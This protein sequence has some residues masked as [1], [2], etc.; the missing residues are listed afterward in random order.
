MYMCRA[1]VNEY[2]DR[3]NVYNLDEFGAHLD[4]THRF[5]KNVL[6]DYIERWYGRFLQQF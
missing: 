1:C 2:P 5:W 3:H 4:R 6:K